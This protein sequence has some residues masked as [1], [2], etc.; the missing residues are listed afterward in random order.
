MES[1]AKKY[2][3]AAYINAMANLRLGDLKT[4]SGSAELL[5]ERLAPSLAPDAPVFRKQLSDLEEQM[6]L[7]SLK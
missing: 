6:R 1:S 3:V 4:A 2:L 5:R 7:R